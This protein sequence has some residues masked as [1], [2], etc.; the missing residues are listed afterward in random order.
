[1]QEIRKDYPTL[2]IY[3][4]SSGAHENDQL[5]RLG[6]KVQPVIFSKQKDTLIGQVRWRLE[7][8]LIKIPERQSHRA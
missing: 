6:L 7:Q 5:S 3:A 4:D 2:T 1:M 8:G